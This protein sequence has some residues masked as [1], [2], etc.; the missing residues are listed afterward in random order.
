M[1]SRWKSVELIK[2]LERRSSG[3]FHGDTSL[4]G[5]IGCGTGGSS[6]RYFAA[7]RGG[8]RSLVRFDP[9]DQWRWLRHWQRNHRLPFAPLDGLAL[10]NVWRHPHGAFSVR[11]PH[12]RRLLVQS[13]VVRDSNG[14]DLLVGCPNPNGV[15]PAVENNATGSVALVLPGV[16]RDPG[17]LDLLGVEVG[18]L[19]TQ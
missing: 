6:S 17:Q 3:T 15:S 18:C 19:Q 8:R 12:H 1:S 9:G 14:S 2:S 11:W 13:R 10:P 16:G 4:A 5:S 7:R